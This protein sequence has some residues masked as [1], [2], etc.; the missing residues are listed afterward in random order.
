MAERA[1]FKEIPLSMDG[2]PQTKPI[3]IFAD[4]IPIK[5]TAIITYKQNYRQILLAKGKILQGVVRRV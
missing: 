2:P 4:F 3:F 1:E 5:Y